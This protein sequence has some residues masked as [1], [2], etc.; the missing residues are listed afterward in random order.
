MQAQKLLNGIGNDIVNELVM[1][2]GEHFKSGDLANSISYKIENGKI[3]I[4]MLPYWK[5]VEYGTPGVKEGKTSTVAGNTVSFGPNINR[6]MPVKKEGDAWVNLITG[7]KGDWALA[8]HIQMYG[9]SPYPFLRPVIYHK[10]QRI[11]ERNMR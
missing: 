10:L 3:N 6:K 4:Y 11:V 5:F 1:G 7:M 2:L 9:T 8:K